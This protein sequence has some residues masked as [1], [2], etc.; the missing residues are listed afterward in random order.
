MFALFLALYLK[1]FR[2]IAF[3]GLS[4]WRS[5]VAAYLL[6][7]SI[8]VLL[9]FWL[10]WNSNL[11]AA[12]GHTSA[13]IGKITAFDTI[14][15]E[16]RETDVLRIA[17]D[18]R[19]LSQ[20]EY[21][22]RES[23]D[24]YQLLVAAI[25]EV[26][27]KT[28]AKGNVMFVSPQVETLLGY[29]ADEFR[30]KGDSLWFNSIHVDD[31]ER[32]GQAFELLLKKGEP[33]DIEC[34]AQKKN[35]EW[36]WAHDRA[37]ATRDSNGLRVA[38]GLI[39]DISVRKA[40]EESDRRYR[41]LFENMLEG[42]AHCE[43][44]F[45]DRG[46]PIDFVYLAVNSTFEKL[47]GLRNVVGR[48]FTEIIPEGKDS[49]AELF[50][51]YGRVALTGM[52]ERFE[53]EVKG[54]GMWFSISAYGAGKGCF[55]AVFDNITE[56]K[57][58]EESLLFKTALLEA[59]AETTIDG[60]LVVD[61]SGHIVLANKQFALHFGIPDD[62]LRAQDDRIVLKHL[63]TKI[64]APE[65][66]VERVQYLYGH[67]D[68]KSRDE[69][70]LKNGKV[71]DRYS[72]PLIDPN[73]RYRGRIWYFRD[74]SER[75]LAEE[76]VQFLAFYDALTG[77]PNRTLFQDRLTTALA[78]ARRQKDKVALLF[79]DL[80]KFKDINDSLGHSVGDLLLKEVAERLKTWGR[81]QD[82]VAR[83]AGDEFLITLTQVKD[84]PD[85][86]VAA[87]RLMEAMIAG[88]FVQGHSLNV[89]C[90]IGIS[91][92]P[93][94]GA[95]GETL[96]KNA[97]AAMYRAKTDGRNNFRFFTED[98][99]AKAVER[100][101]LEK[102]LRSALA[103]EELFLMYQPQMDI[104]TGRITGLEALLRW[105]HPDLGLVPPDRFIRIAENSALIVPIGE[106]V[107]RTACRQA[108]KWQDEGL[109]A[110]TVAVNVSA[111]QFRQA[112]FCGLIGR[113]LHETGLAPQYLELELTE[114]L[115]LAE[116]DVTLSV[117]KELKSMGVTLA[118]D[119][120]GTGYS[121]FNYLRQFRVSKL[122]IDR[123]FIRDV[124]MNPDDA[125]ITAAII[126]MAKSL[127]LKVIAEGV[128]NEAQ[129]SFLRAHLCDEI[130]GY[131]FSKPLA[132]D[133]VADKL[134][135]N[136]PAPKA[137]AQASGKQA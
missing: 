76:R 12:V 37:V 52:P 30:Q 18:F 71:F 80:D 26:V 111:V 116:A 3:L 89:S 85:V 27:W 99:N 35:G 31:K 60:I 58:A 97:D 132:D 96:I 100:V 133:K 38:T 93:G 113:V 32:V 36:F 128:E 122:K 69:F 53:T 95:D 54:L 81:E 29:S 66:F 56:R 62:L 77:L 34:R 126:S 14:T 82:T 33:Y 131:Y 115:L 103:R 101:A 67:R 91:I 23:E 25:P 117:L 51:R 13:A 137:L 106:W 107:V 64:E 50:E 86:A 136:H 118:I 112:D 6:C 78:S 10:R 90:S 73:G 75:K 39:S 42:F 83:L 55:V 1:R 105:Q 7:A 24:Q 109:P 70:T 61:E 119:D 121:S 65:P 68:E 15:E 9:A 88:F 40:G 125:A 45:D 20:A 47:T 94:H 8:V 108:K 123:I 21:S 72:A 135:G 5:H 104:A 48:K 49:H 19:K 4:G 87:E 16:R 102:S 114:S 120:F 110:V 98:M 84:V 28:D 129:M 124:A 127:N 41:S 22:L 17:G 46:R 92:F 63:L 74:I 43:M 44:V 11:K 57:M 79:L 2:Q 130:Q 59:Q 134:R